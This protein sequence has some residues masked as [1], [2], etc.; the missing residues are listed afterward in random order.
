MQ[1]MFANLALT[2][3]DHYIPRPFWNAF[4]DYD[5]QRLNLREHQDAYEFFTRLQVLICATCVP[6]CLAQ[7]N[8]PAPCH[9]CPSLLDACET[10]SH[11]LYALRVSFWPCIVVIEFAAEYILVSGSYRTLLADLTH[12]R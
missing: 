1:N 3:Q 4:K 5:G 2:N 8:L 10:L 11:N 7:A 9:M 6:H 12:N